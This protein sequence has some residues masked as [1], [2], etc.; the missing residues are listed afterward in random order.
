MLM[1]YAADAIRASMILAESFMEALA[2]SF[3]EIS[4]IAQPL[5]WG[6]S[7][8]TPILM[9]PKVRHSQLIPWFTSGFK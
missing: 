7:E 8:L 2:V 9:S 6:Y 3:R 4:G 1:Q 5:P